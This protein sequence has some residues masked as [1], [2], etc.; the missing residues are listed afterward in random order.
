MD[1]YRALAKDLMSSL[2]LSLPPIAIAFCDAVPPGVAAFDGVV[3]AGCSFWQEA[4]TRTFVTST[5]DHELCSIGVHTHHMSQPSASQQNELQETLRAMSGLDYVRAEEVAAIQASLQ[6][7][8][9]QLHVKR[10]RHPA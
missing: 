7:A 6:K 5:K 4:A 9:A 1:D 10:R 8:L 2:E 3:P